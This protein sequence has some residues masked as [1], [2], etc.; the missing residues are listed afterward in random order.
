MA[1]DDSHRVSL[2]RYHYPEPHTAC[3]HKNS[4]WFVEFVTDFGNLPLIAGHV[5]NL[6]ALNQVS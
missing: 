2:L 6:R 3:S 1:P 5:A 4:S